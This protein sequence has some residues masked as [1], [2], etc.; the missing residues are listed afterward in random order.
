MLVTWTLLGI[1]YAGSPQE[2]VEQLAE[3]LDW[4]TC[5][6]RAMIELQRRPQPAVL[7]CEPSIG[8]KA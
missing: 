4:D 8:V 3:R 7:V 5:V 6:A 1:L 2:R